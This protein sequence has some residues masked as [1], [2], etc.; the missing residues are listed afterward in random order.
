MVKTLLHDWLSINDI[1]ASTNLLAERVLRDLV[2]MLYQGE[3]QLHM[4]RYTL[5]IS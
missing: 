4:Y 3:I 2:T 1:A 5:Q